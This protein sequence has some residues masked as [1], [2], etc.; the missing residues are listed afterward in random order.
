MMIGSIIAGFSVYFVLSLLLVEPRTVVPIAIAMSALIFGLTKYYDG[1][2]VTINQTDEIDSKLK[3]KEN[4]INISVYKN[5]NWKPSTITFVTIFALLIFIS[6]FL[7]SKQDFHIYVAWNE[8]GVS[9]IIHLA[10]A[11]MLCFFVPGYA[12]VL[13]T[14]SAICSQSDIGHIAWLS[15]EHFDYWDDRIYFCIIF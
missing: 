1:L 12:I 7:S 11:I 4:N 15:I 6:S 9:G 14:N 13:C 3:D 5:E 10:A 2:C 8:I